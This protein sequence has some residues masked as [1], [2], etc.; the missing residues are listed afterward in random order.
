MTS[1][2]TA[3]SHL[4]SKSSLNIIKMKAKFKKIYK[5]YFF[6]SIIKENACYYKLYF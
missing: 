4:N 1:M 6:A 3:P 2:L 5:Q